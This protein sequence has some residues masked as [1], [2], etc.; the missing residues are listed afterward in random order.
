M[1]IGLTPA[2]ELEYVVWAL[3]GEVL[4]SIQG[5]S[6]EKEWD[7]DQKLL[8]ETPSRLRYFVEIW[9][10][11]GR[12]LKRMWRDYYCECLRINECYNKQPIQLAWTD[13]NR[14]GITHTFLDHQGGTRDEEAARFFL[15][16]IWNSQNEKL[17]GP[18]ARCGKY[19]IR[20]TAGNTKYCTRVCSSRATAVASTQKKRAEEHADKI[21]RAQRAADKWPTT[22][23]KFDWKQWIS[24]QEPDIT[25]NFLTRAVRKGELKVPVRR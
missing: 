5:P 7:L 19:F 13:S 22:R 2:E 6:D 23:T 14:A 24:G 3:N 25:S 12:N 8:R 18:C 15:I 20:G 1:E 16:L 10:R 11:S 17:A 9:K 4:F 21:R